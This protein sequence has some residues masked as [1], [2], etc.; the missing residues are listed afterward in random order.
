MT[1]EKKFEPPAYASEWLGEW[2]LDLELVA[3]G[4]EFR[5]RIMLIGARETTVVTL[6]ADQW[7]AGRLLVGLSPYA[8]QRMVRAAIVSV[9]NPAGYE[10]WRLCPDGPK[11]LRTT[12]QRT[13]VFKLLDTIELKRIEDAPPLVQRFAWVCL[14][15]PRTL[16]S[17]ALVM[18]EAALI[19][20]PDCFQRLW[21]SPPEYAA[22]RA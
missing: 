19:E 12:V 2:R 11:G 5:P 15:E 4:V 10:T 1:G 22:A 8:M 6:P 18:A 17:Y 3:V 13:P 20:Q 21:S 7:R 9:P 16:S 14:R